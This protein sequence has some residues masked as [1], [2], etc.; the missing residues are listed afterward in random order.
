MMTRDELAA[1]L[2]LSLGSQREIHMYLIIRTRSDRLKAEME[3]VA[4]EVQQLQKSCPHP[5]GGDP[6]PV[7]GKAAERIGDTG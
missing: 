2:L 4:R 1:E 6:C 7:C 5:I 3:N